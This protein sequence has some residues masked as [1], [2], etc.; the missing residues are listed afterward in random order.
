MLHNNIKQN[1]EQKTYTLIYI[2]LSGDLEI[3]S[4]MKASST[5]IHTLNDI[6]EFYCDGSSCGLASLDNSEVLLKPVR[7]FKHPVLYNGVIVVC[8]TYNYKFIKD[9]NDNSIN[10]ETVP[11]KTNYRYFAQ[12][13]YNTS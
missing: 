10:I 5:P 2:W 7:F 3:L 1:P 4:K 12:E 6:P 11:S 13:L 9:E 8:S